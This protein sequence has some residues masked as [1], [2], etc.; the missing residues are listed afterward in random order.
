MCDQRENEIAY[1][2]DRAA[3]LREWLGMLQAFPAI[4]DEFK[5]LAVFWLAADSESALKATEIF[6]G[7]AIVH[8]DNLTAAKKAAVERAAM[9]DYSGPE[10]I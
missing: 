7:E 9:R 2:G 10:I 4:E 3:K 6:L 5:S 8:L 1:L